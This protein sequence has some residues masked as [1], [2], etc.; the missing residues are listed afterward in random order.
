[1]PKTEQTAIDKTP[2]EERNIRVESTVNDDVKFID[3]LPFYSLRAACGYFGE[4]ENVSEEG[5]IQVSNLGR[6][7]RNMFVVQASGDSMNPLIQDGD[8]CVFR[9]N[10]IGSRNGKVVLVQHRNFYDPDSGGSYSIK[11]YTSSKTIDPETGEWCHEQILLQPLNN[12]YTPIKIE[13]S[14][15]E[16]C[17]EFI[18]IGEFIGKITPQTNER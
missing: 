8:Y 3:F 7:N 2:C 14:D 15:L 17:E 13:Y 10:I 1:M 12:D 5:W 4:G 16:D 6:L 9:S 18:V 11:K